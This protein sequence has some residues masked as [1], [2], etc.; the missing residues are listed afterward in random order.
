MDLSCWQSQAC[1]FA[2]IFMAPL[3]QGGWLC[4]YFLDVFPQLLGATTHESLDK[5]ME[6]LLQ[7]EKEWL[8]LAFDMVSV[9][10][11][12]R[13]QSHMHTYVRIYLSTNILQITVPGIRTYVLRSLC[14]LFLIC[15]C[16]ITADWCLIQRSVLFARHRG[17]G[18]RRGL[19]H[20]LVYSYGR[21]SGHY[22]ICTYVH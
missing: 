21:S 16:H 18:G 9:C 2:Y 6:A 15:T 3:L 11:S 8:I 17:F 10:T 22:V 7:W 14:H 12:K 5:K 13:H 1:K 19:V 4:K 20:K